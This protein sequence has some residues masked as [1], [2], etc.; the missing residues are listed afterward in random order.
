MKPE[1]I[2]EEAA[3]RRLKA[4]AR[5]WPPSLWLYSADGTLCVMRLDD[6][7]RRGVMENRP[8]NP[9]YC[10]VDPDYIVDTIDI[11]NDGGDW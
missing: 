7:G 9:G 10:G 4:L 11:P 8:V 1:A 2:S 5:V 3:I 6:L